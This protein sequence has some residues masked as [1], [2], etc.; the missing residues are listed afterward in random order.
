MTPSSTSCS[1]NAT[2]STPSG[3]RCC[4]SAPRRPSCCWHSPSG[5]WRTA[6]GTCGSSS[7]G[8]GALLAAYL[9]LLAPSVAQLPSLAALFVLLGVFYAATDGVL[10]AAAAPLLPP[11]LRASGLALVQTGQAVGRF[12]AAVLFGAAWTA[13]GPVTA[14]AAAVSCL[15]AALALGTLLLR[16]K[17]SP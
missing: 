14:L 5:D 7:C 9:L 1:S 2:T 10:M 15:A 13:T 8:H 3:S 6:P 12:A 17:A 4:R 11:D 16:R